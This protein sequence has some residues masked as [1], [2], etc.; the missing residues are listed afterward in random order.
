MVSI[1][2]AYGCA[3]GCVE[4][5]IKSDMLSVWTR[6]IVRRTVLL[7]KQKQMAL[8]SHLIS[9]YTQPGRIFPGL[10]VGTGAITKNCYILSKHQTFTEHDSDLDCL[11]ILRPALLMTLA[12]RVLSRERDILEFEKVQSAAKSYV[13]LSS[14]RSSTEMKLFWKRPQRVSLIQSLQDQITFFISLFYMNTKLC[15]EW[16]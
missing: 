16:R 6:N 5:V 15:K 12:E 1:F 11:S 14:A 3:Y 4:S 2:P 7:L 13:K 10:C 9:K 8:M